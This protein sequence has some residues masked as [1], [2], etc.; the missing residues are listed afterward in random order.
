V[1][2]PDNAQAR[3]SVAKVIASGGVIAFR[4][5]TFYG[6]GADPFNAAAITRIRE[7]KGSEGNKPILLLIADL[8]DVA[9]F[10]V[11]RSELF[12]ALAEKFWPGP[13]TIVD[14][15]SNQLPAVLTSGGGTIGLRLPHDESVRTLLRLCGGALTATSAN[16]SG[17]PPAR[18]AHEV[19]GYFGEAL[20][21]IL[22]GGETTV[23]EPSTVVDVHADE[24]III[25][26]GA[27]NAER[28]HSAIAELKRF[29]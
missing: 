1:I 27:L 7:L 9:R 18:T 22:D 26:A 4:T 20:E 16:I 11:S 29:N 12:T 17:K 10:V 14:S 28:I 19:A 25:R 3:P 8:S 13:L 21:L 2:V 23:T 15:A 24:P 6:L 5:D